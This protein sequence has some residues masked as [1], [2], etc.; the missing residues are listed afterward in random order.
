MNNWLSAA[1]VL[2]ISWEEVAP[3]VFLGLYFLAQWFMKSKA[4]NGG[5]EQEAASAA[6]QEESAAAERARRLQEEI[7][8]RIAEKMREVQDAIQPEEKESSDQR[9]MERRQLQQ[10]EK[11]KEELVQP[12]RAPVTQVSTAAASPAQTFSAVVNEGTAESS[13]ELDARLA[14]I[15][16]AQSVDQ[17]EDNLRTASAYALDQPGTVVAGS[18]LAAL[19]KDL[20]DPTNLKKAILL[21]EILEKPVSMR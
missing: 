10:Q 19:M 15:R 3:L 20:K 9:P 11:R 16:A 4:K 2:G 7:R 6:E 21:T 8:R 12:E 17:L 18:Q 1:L 13:S 14:S 5:D